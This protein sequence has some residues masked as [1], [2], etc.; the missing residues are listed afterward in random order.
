M[1]GRHYQYWVINYRDF[2]LG[3]H[4]LNSLAYSE[5]G[6]PLCCELPNGEAQVGQQ[7][8]QEAGT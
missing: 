3:M 2:H 5:G 4:S 1:M 7:Q 8:G 6:Q